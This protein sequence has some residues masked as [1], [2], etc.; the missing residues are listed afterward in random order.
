MTASETLLAF[1]RFDW[2]EDGKTPSKNGSCRPLCTGRLGL[3]W[4]DGATN[5]RLVITPKARVKPP[6]P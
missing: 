3:Q 2:L 6:L 5:R 4:W 1:G